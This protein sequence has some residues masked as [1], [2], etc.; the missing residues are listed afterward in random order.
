MEIDATRHESSFLSPTL[1]WSPGP[2]AAE[3]AATR[4]ASDETTTKASPARP[5]Q[6]PLLRL[7][8]PL[9]LG[10]LAGA[11]A[12]L[13]MSVVILL[14]RQAGF[15]PEAPPKQIT[16]RVEARVGLRHHLRGP[17][18]EASWLAAHIGYGALCGALYPLIGRWLPG[19]PPVAGLLYGLVVWADSY[20]GLL[21]RLGLFPSPIHDRP[22]RPATMIAAHLVYGGALA[23]AYARL[24]RR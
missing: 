16:A 11:L 23:A 22:A 14:G 4:A 18:F 7:A 19:S 13:P 21:P 10:G 12:T 1:D 24:R 15:L 9:L 8:R 3:M 2:P 17:A 20:L 6:P 5:G